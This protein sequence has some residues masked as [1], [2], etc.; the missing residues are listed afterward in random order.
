M[1]NLVQIIS[2]LTVVSFGCSKNSKKVDP[3][4]LESYTIEI[5]DSIKVDYQGLLTVV[6]YCQK[7]NL[8]LAVDGSKA[9]AE[10]IIFDDTGQAR[11]EFDNNQAGPMA[12]SGEINSLSFDK[13]CNGFFLLT[14]QGLYQY[15]IKG[16][17]LSYLT[18]K[19]QG[20]RILPSDYHL[21]DLS[22]EN[23]VFFSLHKSPSRGFTFLQKEFYETVKMYSL[24]DTDKGEFLPIL[25]FDQNSDY[26]TRQRL[27][28]PSFSYTDFDEINNSIYVAHSG[29]KNLYSYNYTNNEIISRNKIPLELDFFTI[30][31]ENYQGY[32]LD[33]F[34]FA[35][36]SRIEGLLYSQGRLIVSYIKG[37]NHDKFLSNGLKYNGDE[38]YMNFLLKNYQYCLSILDSGQKL[39]KDIILP[40]SLSKPI[41]AFSKNEFLIGINRFK[42]EHE[43]EI[44]YKLKLNKR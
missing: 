42:V 12:Y 22:N 36:D 39:R 29:D 43:N 18:D 19:N 8:Y 14:Q 33:A 13:D 25:G 26:L 44:F 6:D 23:H 40:D 27:F 4:E 11:L 20:G 3:T 41:I 15:D 30:K 38:N 31:K 21:I 35:L 7:Q 1:K 24:I 10:F 32:D 28:P 2:L 17:L 16:T 9:G 34:E 37:M 5:Y